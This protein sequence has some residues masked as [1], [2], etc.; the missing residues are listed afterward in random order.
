MNPRDVQLLVL[1]KQPVPGTVKTRLCPPCSPLDAAAIA[2][3]SLNDT[4]S[5]V[6]ATPARARILVLDGSLPESPTAVEVIAQKGD[7]LDERLANAFEDAGAPSL[8]I[9]MDTP[10]ISPQLLQRA[11]AALVSPGTDA[12]LGPTADGGYWAIGLRTTDPDVFIGIPMSTAATFD[13]QV[14][15]LTSLR[16]NVALLP[17]LIDV[18]RFGDSV[19]VAAQIPGSD[20]ASA[21]ERVAARL[22]VI[23]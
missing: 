4:L 22:E 23:R 6:A 19:T 12:V 11:M 9:G 8:L 10:Q 3:A 16:L 5:V 2:E 17:S 21:V 13:R 1:A 18:D 15:R 7:G 20:F 14:E